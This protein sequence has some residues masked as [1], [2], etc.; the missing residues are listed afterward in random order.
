MVN[1]NFSKSVRGEPVEPQNPSTSSGRTVHLKIR[2]LF[3]AMS[4]AAVTVLRLKLEKLKAHVTDAVIAQI[5]DCA[6]KFQIN[7]PLRL[8]H[9]SM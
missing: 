6:A 7:T 5:P 3:L 4:L 1:N 8:A 2:K 9:L